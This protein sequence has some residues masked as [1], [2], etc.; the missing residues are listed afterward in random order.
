MQEGDIILYDEPGRC[1]GI[2]SHC[3]HYRIV[4]HLGGG[5]D[6]LV[7]NGA[8]ESR[9][10]LSNSTALRPILAAMDSNARYWL[11]NS[12]AHGYSDGKARGSESVEA[13]WR[14]AAAE[15][16]IKTRKLPNGRGVKVWIEPAKMEA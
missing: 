6:L 8:G 5:T 12:L 9:I 13:T 2:D 7:K 16:R 11:M 1:G 3:H 10:R 15:K 14:Q 4:S